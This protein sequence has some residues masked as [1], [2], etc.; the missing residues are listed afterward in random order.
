ML[1]PTVQQSASK[2]HRNS[3]SLFINELD[4]P[5]LTTPG[6]HPDDRDTVSA[7]LSITINGAPFSCRSSFR[8]SS[9]VQ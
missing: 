4:P 3:P 9:N 2:L 5:L 8:S 6:Q 7:F 1:D